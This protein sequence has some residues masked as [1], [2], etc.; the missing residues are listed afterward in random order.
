MPCLYFQI[1]RYSYYDN[2][3]STHQICFYVSTPEWPFPA[4]LVSVKWFSACL[5]TASVDDGFPWKP[6]RTSET[7]TRK[8]RHVTRLFRGSSRLT[9]EF[10]HTFLKSLESDPLVRI[11]SFKTKSDLTETTE[12]DEIRKPHGTITKQNEMSKVRLIPAAHMPVC[13]QEGDREQFTLQV[14]NIN[15]SK[16]KQTE[17]VG[18]WK[19]TECLI[20]DLNKHT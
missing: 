5:I 13:L 1:Y 11:Q 14:E 8:Y 16:R 10:L 19:R 17:G 12:R 9:C 6:P 7:Q 18:Q 20:E 15:K 3:T 2:P 4:L